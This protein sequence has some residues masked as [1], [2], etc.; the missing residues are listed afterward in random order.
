MPY[1]PPGWPIE[2]RPPGAPDWE[3][4][5]SAWLLDLC[6]PEYRGYPVLRKHVLVL[7]RFAAVH[8]EAC[9]ES[10][11]RGI[12]QVR[13]ELKDFVPAGVVSTSLQAW[14]R[15]EARLLSRRREVGLVEDALRGRTFVP[16]L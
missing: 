15:E 10:V 9:Q 6:P 5:A 3:V 11:R 2:V 14:Q 16:R 12:S 8:V 7:A 1:A 4:S 13:D